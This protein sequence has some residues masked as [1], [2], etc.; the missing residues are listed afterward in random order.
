MCGLL[1]AGMAFGQTKKL[2]L[3]NGGFVQGQV[4]ET[5]GAYLV[6]SDLGIISVI[7]KEQVASIEEVMTLQDEYQKR[8]ATIDPD[9]AEDHYELARW[10]FTNNWLKVAETESMK[11]LELRKDY[12]Q[13]TLLLRQVR[14]RRKAGPQTQPTTAPGSDALERIILPGRGQLDMNWFVTDEEISRIVLEEL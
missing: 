2:H 13:A 4:T 8:L 7:L 10:A 9:K 3:V 1:L 12:E 5:D 11:A 6:Q 14:A